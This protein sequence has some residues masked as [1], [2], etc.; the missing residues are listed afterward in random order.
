MSLADWEKNGWLRVHQTN[1][2]QI[3]ELF[4][5]VDRDLEDAASKDLSADWKFGIAY[6][7]A[8]K[9]CTIL[10]YAEGY[11]TEKALAHYRSLQSLPLIMG[12][13]AKADADYLDTCRMKRNTV[14]YDRSGA[15]SKEEA[16]ELRAF[17]QDLRKA[18]I[19][20][21]SKYHPELNP[22]NT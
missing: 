7:A 19:E 16:E 4:G 15:A 21:L 13:K 20:W 6:N 11:R 2:K 8:L 14:E 5:I 9:L 1:K 17:T 18:V 12:D 3:A 10:L 22:Y